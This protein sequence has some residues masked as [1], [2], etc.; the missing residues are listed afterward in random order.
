MNCE[1]KTNKGCRLIYAV[2]GSWRHIPKATCFAKCGQTREQQ[3][4]MLKQQY[5]IETPIDELLA[6]RPV[7]TE[8]AT[9]DR[10]CNG[11]G[12]VKNIVK[13]FGRLVWER[14][15]KGKPDEVT[16]QRAEIC[17]ACEHRTFLNV[18]QWAI[19]AVHSGDLPI[20]HEPG[21]WD[22]LWCSICKCC[23]EAKIRVPDEQCPM[24]KWPAS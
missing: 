12:K 7:T 6:Q 17:A 20:N 19:N 11:C 21:D 23:I 1:H 22:A 4:V 2:T 14:V 13:G 3:Q 16:T 24:G 5:G 18:S 8:P 15:T 10:G 9:K